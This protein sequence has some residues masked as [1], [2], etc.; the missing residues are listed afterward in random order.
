M[1]SASPG[2]KVFFLIRLAMT[3][4]VTTFIVVAWMLGGRGQPAS[5]AAASLATL[6]TVM[7]VAVGVA[8]AVIMALKLRLAEAE[9]AMRRSLSVVAWAVGEFAAL[10]GGVMLFLTGEW[11]F[12]L[13]G[14]LVFA[15]SLSVVRMPE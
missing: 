14:A 6:T 7:Y 4:G 8:A 3:V 13:P 11:R 9:P 15:M 12:V 10:F 1:A 5:V 2:A